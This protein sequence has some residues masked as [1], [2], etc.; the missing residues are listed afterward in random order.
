MPTVILHILGEEP[1]QGE[2]KKLPAAGDNLIAV[3]HP[4]R[5][6]G[7]DLDNIEVDCVVVLWPITRINLIEVVGVDEEDKIITFVREQ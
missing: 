3:H 7:R 5:K 6:D 4:R 1:V 2:V